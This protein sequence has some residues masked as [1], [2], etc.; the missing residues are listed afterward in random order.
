MILIIKKVVTKLLSVVLQ[1]FDLQV[2]ML[3]YQ[4]KWKWDCL[5]GWIFT[6]IFEVY[7]NP[8]KKRTTWLFYGFSSQRKSR[9]F[10]AKSKTTKEILMVLLAN[11]TSYNEWEFTYFFN[12]WSAGEPPSY[13]FHCQQG[14]TTLSFVTSRTHFEGGMVAKKIG[15]QTRH[16]S[17]EL[18]PMRYKHDN[19]RNVSLFATLV[20]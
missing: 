15:Y 11:L 2:F 9:I 17:E 19:L 4:K 6:S 8:T 14:Q 7:K 16:K 5:C 1:L 10:F 12:K 20:N 3:R 18:W 13:L